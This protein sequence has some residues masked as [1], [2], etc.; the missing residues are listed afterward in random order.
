MP[1]TDTRT[2][3]KAMSKT[4]KPPDPPAPSLPPAGNQDKVCYGISVSMLASGVLLTGWMWF[5]VVSNVAHAVSSSPVDWWIIA[6]MVLLAVGSF[7]VARFFLWL[8]VLA[9]LMLAAQTRSYEAQEKF[10]QIALKYRRFLPA[11][12]SWASQ[13]LMQLMLQRGQLKEAIALGI[14]EY[15]LAVKK[16]P[17]D[18]SVAPTCAQLGVAHQMNN[19]QHGSILWSE[20]AVEAY[21]PLLESME[22]PDDKKKKFLPEKQFVDQA[23]MQ[24]ASIYCNLATSYLNVGNYGK[25]KGNYMRATEQAM[26]LPDTPEKQQ[27]IQVSRDQMARLKHW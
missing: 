13:G 14:S 20:R 18:Q 9:P 7:F 3:N 4:S 25:A 19:D 12:A 26:K 11:A 8:S 15:E 16:N 10:C 21:V 17:K 27:I 22:K 2:A 1:K 24:L 6:G 23:R 5:T